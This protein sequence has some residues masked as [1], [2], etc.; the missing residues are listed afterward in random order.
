MINQ[1]NIIKNYTPMILEQKK[2]FILEDFGTSL[3][4]QILKINGHTL[5]YY[6]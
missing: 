5:I 2:M 1:K 3:K 4:K 6:F